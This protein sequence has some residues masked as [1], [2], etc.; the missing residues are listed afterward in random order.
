MVLPSWYEPQ[1]DNDDPMIVNDAGFNFRSPEFE[2]LEKLLDF[3]NKED[4]WVTLVFWGVNPNTF[5]LPV[6]EPGW[7]FGPAKYDEWAEYV[8]LCIKDLVV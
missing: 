4:I 5:M 8:R 7:I 1:N 3:C 6:S 2:A